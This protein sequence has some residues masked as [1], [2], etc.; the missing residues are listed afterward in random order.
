MFD[1]ALIMAGGFVAAAVS[2]AAGFGGALLLLPLLTHMA[3]AKVAVPLLT[4]AQLTGNLA[5]IGFNAQAIAWRPVGLFLLGAVPAAALGALSFVSLREDVVVRAVGAALLCFVLL[6]VTGVLTLRPSRSLLIGGGALTGF[7]SGLVGSAGPLGAA[8]F[9]SLNLPPPVYIASEAVSAAAMHGLKMAIYGTQ[10][11]L[12]PAFWSVA[13]ALGG[14][15]ILGTWAGK[16]LVEKLSPD[17]FQRLVSVLLSAAAA[18]MLLF[19]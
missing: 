13:F 6:R 8:V 9:L 2:G 3:G 15:M 16:R 1:L 10:L 19:G 14:A 7:L 18:Q 5:R 17:R 11:R 4:V 12:D